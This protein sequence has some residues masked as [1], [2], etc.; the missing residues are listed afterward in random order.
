MTGTQRDSRLKDACLPSSPDTTNPVQPT[1][2]AAHTR[3]QLGPQGLLPVP[4]VGPSGGL[5]GEP[6]TIVVLCV[7]RKREVAALVIM[8]LET[9]P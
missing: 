9:A 5:E 7:H 2:H 3:T 8:A 1:F 6:R 4:K